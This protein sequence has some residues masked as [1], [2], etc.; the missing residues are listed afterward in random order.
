MPSLLLETLQQEK[1][2]SLFNKQE[3]SDLVI[4]TLDGKS[5]NVLK[6]LLIPYSEVF[7]EMFS[8]KDDTSTLNELTLDKIVTNIA[9]E[10]FL[11]VVY[12]GKITNYTLDNYIDLLLFAHQYKMKE[13]EEKCAYVFKE[14]EEERYSEENY[15]QLLEKI[16][17]YNDES[18]WFIEVKKSLMVMITSNFD[19][20]KKSKDFY[21]MSPKDLL[22]LL[23]IDI[24]CTSE[25]EVFEAAMQWIK[26]DFDNRIQ[27]VDE[28]LKRIDLTDL[29]KVLLSKLDRHPICEKSTVLPSLMLQAMKLVIN[30]SLSDTFGVKKRRHTRLTFRFTTLGCTGQNIPSDLSSYKGKKFL[31]DVTIKNGYQ[32]FTVPYTGK[33]KITSV[34]AAGGTNT[35]ASNAS[36]E[37]YGAKVYG[38]FK[39]TKGDVLKILVGQKGE[40]CVGSTGSGAV[41]GGG[42]TFVVLKKGNKPLIIGAGGNGQSWARRIRNCIKDG[43]GGGYI[44]G[45][46]VPSNMYN[47]TYPDYG[48]VSFN[49]GDNQENVGDWNKADG[50]VEIQT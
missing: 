49:S 26:H 47:N 45:K 41:G 43:G 25:D 11:K 10:M 21:L 6:A 34:G 17:K 46:G 24:Y 15:S 44:G 31:E 2:S 14:M 5:Y 12:F 1:I 38:E 27:Y 48:A 23:E 29:D 35:Y 33:Y 40:N 36:R 20:F 28:I 4:Q 18:H 7:E 3:Y 8:K 30:P 22:I 9:L 50:W 19:E 37:G 13:M 32:F 39:L 42:V 16:E